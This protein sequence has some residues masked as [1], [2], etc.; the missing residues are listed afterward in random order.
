M[1]KCRALLF[2]LWLGVFVSPCQA[3]EPANPY[4]YY[5]SDTFNAFIIERAD[6]TDTRVLGDGLMPWPEEDQAMEVDGPGWSPSG[7]WFAWTYA[8]VDA[9][10]GRSE[11][12]NPLIVSADGSTR[13]TLL[14]GLCGVRLAWASDRDVL[15]VAAHEAERIPRENLASLLAVDYDPQTIE[16]FVAADWA[17]EQ[18]RESPM[19]TVYIVY[20]HWMAIDVTHETI[21]SSFTRR[22]FNDYYPWG[23]E[24]AVQTNDHNHFLASYRDECAYFSRECGSWH[25]VTINADG[26]IDDKPDAPLSWL[27]TAG[28]G[29]HFAEEKPRI[30]NVL[31]GEKHA[32]ASIDSIYR[33]EQILWDVSGQYAVITNE[34]LWLLDCPEGQLTLLR[35]NW[36]LADFYGRDEKPTWSPDSSFA[37]FMGTDHVLVAFNRIAGTLTELP[38]DTGVDYRSPEWYWVD[39]THAGFHYPGMFIIYDLVSL[40]AQHIPV[41]IDDNTDPRLSPDGQRLFFVEDGPVIYDMATATYQKFRPSYAGFH[42]FDGGEVVWHTSGEW[43]FVF[44]ESLVAGGAYVRDLGIMRSDGTQRRDLS[45]IRG[46]PNPITVNWLPPQVDPAALP[47]PVTVPLV[48]QPNT[49]L[50]GAHWSFYADWS[51]DGRRLA[52]GLDWGSRDG[53]D[54]NVWEVKTGEIVHV[55]ENAGADERVVWSSGETFIPDLSIPDPDSGG[56]CDYVMARSPDGRHVVQCGKAIDTATG[57]V[58]ADLEKG[59]GFYFDATYSPDGRLLVTASNIHPVEIWDT[60]TWEIIVS[61]PNQGQTVAFSPDGTQLAVTASWDI[62]LWDVAELLG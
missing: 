16:Q 30:E 21:L 22:S 2:V 3:Q 43:A 57:N 34:H 31:T 42:S 50:H 36:E 27:S 52:A 60:T 45:F 41:E 14:D 35:E 47:S 11:I 44:E 33:S 17:K 19:E 12:C 5:Y 38:V 54:I 20:N 25:I 10:G 8:Y 40:T 62:Q 9:Y 37:L 1:S 32:V 13:L 4:I 58:L 6:G 61:L 53:G 7:R 56:G 28:W 29:I 39:N 55:F 48:A 59:C 46:I 23:V 26:T 51:P 18:Q 24:S 15:F 49:T